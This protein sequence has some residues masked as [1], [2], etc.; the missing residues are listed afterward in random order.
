M[1]SSVVMVARL[2]NPT[3]GLKSFVMPPN[4]GV[5]GRTPDD[6]CRERRS[7]PLN[8]SFLDPKTNLREGPEEPPTEP[9]SEAPCAGGLRLPKAPAKRSNKRPFLQ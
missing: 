8:D 5:S 3:G 9:A 6:R 7:R 1:S 2:G 4:E